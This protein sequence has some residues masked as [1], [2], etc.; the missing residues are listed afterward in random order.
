MPQVDSP[1]VLE[2]FHAWLHLA[3]IVAK[4]VFPL[5]G[6]LVELDDLIAA[7]REGLLAAARRYDPKRD[8]PFRAFA[9][10]RIRGAILDAVRRMAPLSRR[11]HERIEGLVAAWLVSEGDAE[12]VFLDE[13]RPR[14]AASEEDALR[15]DLGGAATAVAAAMFGRAARSDPNRLTDDGSSDPEEALA[16]AEVVAQIERAL[17]DEFPRAEANML[18]L[19]YFEGLTIEAAA[20]RLGINRGFASRLHTRGVA[21]LRKRVRGSL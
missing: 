12:L 5:I 3:D 4:Q 17:N 13:G 8:V 7:G 14:D 15:G 10:V 21:R 16:R 11:A 18:R 9:S 6:R 2:R 19:Y 20:E 1:E